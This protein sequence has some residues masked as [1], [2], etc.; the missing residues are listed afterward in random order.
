MVAVAL[1][2]ASIKHIEQQAQSSL[3]W[4]NAGLGNLVRS[5]S[6][7]ISAAMLQAVGCRLLESYLMKNAL[8]QLLRSKTGLIVSVGVT[9]IWINAAYAESCPGNPNALGT[10]R[11]VVVSPNDYTRVGAI[12][13]RDS[14]P[15]ADK[16]M[17]I[18]FDDG[19]L[20]PWSTRILDTLS[21]QCVKATFFLVGEMARNFPKVVQRIHED[22]HT[23]GTHSEDH[24]LRFYKLSDN[25]LRW[26]IDEGIADVAAAVGNTQDV[27]PFF[28]IPGFGRSEQVED[29]LGARKLVTFSADVVAD[30]WHRRITPSQIIV[31]AMKR[32][33][34][35]GKGILLLHDIHKAT[36]AAL[37]RLLEAL[38]KDGFKVVQMVAPN[39]APVASSTDSK[40]ATSVH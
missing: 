15:L 13:Y 21:S 32:L 7:Q 30:D 36:A 38:K 35:R 17:V 4:P 37:P 9:I 3:I 33:E 29:A 2:T 20:P 14:L 40:P 24:P 23:I 27:A 6:V 26:E 5:T 1:I 18:T 12:Q 22:G 19:P 16:E 10:S 25:D 34:E 31:R 39:G 28:R 11:T 8:F